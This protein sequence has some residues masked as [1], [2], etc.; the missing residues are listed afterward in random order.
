M[1]KRII[2]TK[3]RKFSLENKILKLKKKNYKYTEKTDI[4]RMS[5]DDL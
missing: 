5:P 1:H 3:I 4:E 2:K